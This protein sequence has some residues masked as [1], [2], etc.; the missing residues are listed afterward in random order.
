MRRCMLLPLLDTNGLLF[1][2]GGES[3]AGCVEAGSK[4]RR[5]RPVVDGRVP[6]ENGLPDASIL[7]GAMCDVVSALFGCM[8]GDDDRSILNEYIRRRPPFS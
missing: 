3:E 4:G 6:F 5:C 2:V 1:R 7:T 8:F